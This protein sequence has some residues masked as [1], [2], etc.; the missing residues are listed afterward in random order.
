[1]AVSPRQ[2]G[3]EAVQLLLDLIENPDQL[4]QKIILQP[5][6]VIRESCGHHLRKE[7]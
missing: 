5:Q 1:M 2:I 6:L 3:A 4:P 7:I